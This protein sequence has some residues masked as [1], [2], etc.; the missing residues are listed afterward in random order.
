[1]SFVLEDEAKTFDTEVIGFWSQLIKR[2]A[3]SHPES[4][5]KMKIFV[6]KSDVLGEAPGEGGEGG[7][8]GIVKTY[9]SHDGLNSHDYDLFSKFLSQRMVTESGRMSL[10]ALC[11]QEGSRKSHSVFAGGCVVS[12]RHSPSNTT[13]SHINTT[14]LRTNSQRRR[15]CC[16][17]PFTL[18][19]LN[20]KEIFL[21]CFI[22][23]DVLESRDTSLDDPRCKSNLCKNPWLRCNCNWPP[24]TWCS[25]LA[26]TKTLSMS[27]PS[28]PG[29]TV[30]LSTSC[31][32]LKVDSRNDV[33][34][35]L[36]S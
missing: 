26:K 4:C 17:M 19:F 35:E 2:D 3:T 25:L 32:T 9:L 16:S 6:R 15:A 22:N 24:C 14:P 27:S 10:G 34:V 11:C 30:S 29:S 7:V 33:A 18:P 8:G 36:L 31:C 1:M 28:Q 13:V 5:L 23:S 21:A 12:C 20:R